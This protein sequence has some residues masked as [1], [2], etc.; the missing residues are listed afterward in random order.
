MRAIVLERFGIENIKIED[1]NDESPGI[2]VKITM[3]GLNPVDYSTV[4]G[5]IMYG[6]KPMPH[7]PGSEAIGIA[8][9]DGNYIKRGDRVIIYNRIFDGTCEQCITGNEH[10]CLNGG[11]LGVASN[12]VYREMIKLPEMNLFKIP[13]SIDD[14]VAAS[15]GVGALTA[16]RALKT[17][18]IEAGKTILVYGAGNTGIFTAQLARIFGLETYVLSR[19]KDLERYNINVLDSVPEDFKA[20]YI[21]NPLGGSIFEESLRHIKTGGKI[22]TFGILTGREAKIDIGSLYANEIK[23]YGSTGG[24]RKDLLELIKIISMNRIYLPVEKTFSLWDLKEAMNYFKNRSTGRILL[25]A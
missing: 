1:I 4:N 22:V 19:K 15:M 23:I 17:M 21:I 8:M 6:V 13:D 10:L 18:N 2:P 25:K 14:Y 24:T 5:N 12:G 16:Y 11:I 20:D 9:A 7:V 3:A